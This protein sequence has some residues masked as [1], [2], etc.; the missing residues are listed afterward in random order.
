MMRLHDFLEY[1]AR[2]NPNQDFAIF[3]DTKLTYAEADALANQFAN[4]LIAQGLQKGDRIAYLSKNSLEYPVVFYGCSKAGVVPVPLNFRLAPPEWAY[5]INDSG[6]KLLLVSPEYAEGIDSVRDTLETVSDYVIMGSAPADGYRSFYDWIGEQSTTSPDRHIESTDELYQMYTSGTTGN[7][8][9]AVLLQ[10]G[11]TSQVHQFQYAIGRNP[12]ERTLVVAPM[13]HAAAGI[14][15]MAAVAAGG[16]LY[17]MEDFHPVE[18]VRV[19]S[20]ENIAHATLVPAMIQA[21]LVMVPDAASRNYDSLRTMAYGAS[22]IAEETLRNAIS[23]FGCEFYQAYGMTETTAVLTILSDVD[24]Q[25]ALQGEPHLLLSAG[26]PLLGAEIKIV[27]DD[28]NTVTPGTVGEICGRGPQIMN[29]Y[30]NLP[31]ASEKALVDGWMHTGDAGRLDEEGFLYVE[32]RVKDMIISGGENVYPREVEN[33][34]FQHEAVADCAVIGIPDEKWGETIKAI[35]CLKGENEPSIEEFIAFCRERIAHY[36]CP[37]S[38]DFIAE[39]PRNASGKVLKK[40]LREK[41]WEG[42]GRRVS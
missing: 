35:I 32:D 14:T 3:G 8:K 10:E 38:V 1:H 11:A 39:L 12:G 20:E 28:D 42:Q 27:D 31:E 15:F 29:G 22:P 13:Y 19:L 26:R 5:I 41:Y 2:E 23:V 30:W 34:L 33:C 21:C 36:K 17:I 40:D 6:A 37:T 24:H 16:T 18:A 9:G 7:P 25:R 4:A